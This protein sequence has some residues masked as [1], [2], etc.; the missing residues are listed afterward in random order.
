MNQT[1]KTR[2]KLPFHD[3]DRQL[4]AVA[5]DHLGATRGQKWMFNVVDLDGEEY[6]TRTALATATTTEL[7]HKVMDLLHQTSLTE[8]DEW[9]TEVEAWI[10]QIH[11]AYHARNPTA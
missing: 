5:P 6:G 3:G 2:S 8:V 10:N 1:S 11:T 9:S 7:V 4:V